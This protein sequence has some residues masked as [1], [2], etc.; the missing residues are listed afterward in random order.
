MTFQATLK[1]REQIEDMVLSTVNDINHID[2]EGVNQCC[3]GIF[4]DQ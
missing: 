3:D 4:S 2:S 1:E